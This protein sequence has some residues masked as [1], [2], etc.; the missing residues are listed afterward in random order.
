[1]HPTRQAL[2]IPELRLY[3]ASR[4]CSRFARALVAAMLSYHVY[5]VTN[6]YAA[7]GLLGLVEFLPVIPTSLMAGLLADRFDRRRVVIAAYGAA[8]AGTAVL[9]A[10]S[11][12]A[13]ADAGTVF[14]AA[15]ILVIASQFAAPAASA[16]LPGLVP[17]EI[18][19]SATVLSAS[20]TH[21]AWVAGPITM[22]FLVE[23]LGFGAPYGLAALFYLLSI[24]GMAALRAPRIEGE[25]SDISF[26]AVREGLLFVWRA[27]ALLGSMSL[28]MFAVIFASATAL[29]PVFANDIL[30]VG[31]V[32][33]GLLR[34][35]MGIGTLAMAIVL[36]V[37]RPFERPGRVLLQTV[38]VFGLA[39]LAFGL[40]RSFLLSVAA[41]IV[42]GMA[43]QV[44]MITRSVIL[45]MSTPDGLRGRVNAVSM[46]FIGASN[47]LGDAESG[48]LASLTSATFSVV[49]GALCCLGVTGVVAMRLPELSTWRP[50]RAPVRA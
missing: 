14:A 33:Y 44:S 26:S 20:L 12:H 11:Q 22:G 23:P 40:S 42:A 3:V 27:K 29:L 50:P 48:F 16:L 15:F 39:T 28:D 8:A 36:L 6:S 49:A 10:L 34:A 1:M 13:P 35:S 45:Q 30:H 5:A 9:A 43:D 37:V 38:V 19:Q 7:L 47:E 2:G 17:H 46:I 31:P 18:F 41:F 4:F 32:G 21:V 25:P 24:I